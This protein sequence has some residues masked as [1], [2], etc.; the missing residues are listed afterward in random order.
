MRGARESEQWRSN[1][2]E[3]GESEQRARVGASTSK[4]IV[5][6]RRLSEMLEMSETRRRR[7][8]LKYGLES[9]G[10]EGLTLPPVVAKDQR[11]ANLEG[12][13]V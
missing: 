3:S 9:E 7:S 4:S 5:K 11:S 12:W 10:V 2:V 6:G 1:G 13:K 8:D